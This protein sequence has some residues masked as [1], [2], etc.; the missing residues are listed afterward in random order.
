M[1]NGEQK[2]NK[3]VNSQSKFVERNS[4]FSS[5]SQGFC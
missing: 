2:M 4:H 1:R 3:T 5:I